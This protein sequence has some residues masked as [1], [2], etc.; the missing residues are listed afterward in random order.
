MLQQVFVPIDATAASAAA[1][2]L[3]RRIARAGKIELTLLR[4][5]PGALSP[6]E[7][8]VVAAR[9]AV[10]R[11]A[12]GLDGPD[13]PRIGIRVIPARR[14]ADVPTTI[15]EETR[16]RP[17]GLIVMATHGRSGLARLARGSVAEAVLQRSA[18]PVLLLGPGDRQAA[19]GPLGGIVVPL[20]GTPAGAAALGPAAQLARALG[21][22]LFLLRVV[23]PGP[24]DDYSPLLGTYDEADPELRY[25]QAAL[26][27][28]QHYVDLQVAR[29]RECGVAAQGRAVFG[30]ATET[31]I[32]T[33]ERLEA[34]LI[35]LSTHAL[36]GQARAVLGSVADA[37]V[38]QAPCP[39]LL[40]RRDT[41]AGE[42][43]ERAAPRA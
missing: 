22:E 34:G 25:D 42:P 12:A 13:A 3:A 10:G 14:E 40:L 35:A 18:A 41:A 30:A 39:V 5:V 16:A 11:L 26:D 2:P 32:E 36:H 4:V 27:D 43:R 33:A 20:D 7:P 8:P 21:L 31:I 24:A 1:L 38:R 17:G 28:A 9:A 19:G 6:D 37:V 15:A 29:L 23:V